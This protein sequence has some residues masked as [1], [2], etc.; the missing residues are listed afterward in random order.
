MGH[1]PPPME[2]L[3]CEA[4]NLSDIHRRI[5]MRIDFHASFTFED[6]GEELRKALG[7]ATS[8]FDRL[9]RGKKEISLTEILILSEFFKIS[10]PDV[11]LAKF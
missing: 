1:M 8:T 9:K 2:R 7:I 3:P 11:I 4:D 5:G 10:V 6:N